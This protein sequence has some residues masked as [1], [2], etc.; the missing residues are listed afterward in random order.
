MSEPFLVGSTLFLRRN[1][2]NIL[3]HSTRD[4]LRRPCQVR[5]GGRNLPS[6]PK[7]R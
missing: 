7:V 5:D 1:C 2:I 4:D 3:R 6:L